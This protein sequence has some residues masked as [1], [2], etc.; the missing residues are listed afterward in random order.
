MNLFIKL[1]ENPYILLISEW[2]ADF[3]SYNS[4]AQSTNEDMNSSYSCSILDNL[5]GKNLLTSSGISFKRPPRDG[6]IIDK[7]YG[8]HLCFV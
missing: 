8:D 1:V 3:D 6:S 2:K 5:S 7:K 4:S